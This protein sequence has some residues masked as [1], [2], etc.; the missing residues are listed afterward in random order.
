MNSTLA[1][2]LTLEVSMDVVGVLEEA[3]VDIDQE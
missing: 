3:A 2:G 1:N